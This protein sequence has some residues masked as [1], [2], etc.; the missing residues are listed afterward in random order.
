M[1]HRGGA[2]GV[3]DAVIAGNEASVARQLQRMADA[4]TTELVAHPLGTDQ[5]QARTIQTL[6]AFSQG[7]GA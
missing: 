2:A 7:A 3:Q 6:T 1:L 5:E 4:G